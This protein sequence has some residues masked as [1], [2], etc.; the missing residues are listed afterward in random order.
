MPVTVKQ[1]A[2]LAGV[3]R[4]TV[5][6]ALNGRGNVR[7][8][9][10]KKILAIAQEMGYTPNRAGKALA[11]QRKNLS[12]GMIANAEG[13]EFFDEVLRGARTAI[14]EYAD[15]GISLQIAGGRRYDVDQQLSQLE[16]MRSAGVSGIAISPINLPQIEQKIN[17]LIEQG[18]RILTVNSDIEN[19]RRLCYVGCNYYQSGVTAGGMLRLMRPQG[20]RAGIITGSV[21]MLGHNHRMKGFSDVLKSMPDSTVVD[22]C[23]SLDEAEIAYQVTRDMLTSHPEI[24]TLYFAAAGAV[25]GMQAAVDLGLNQ[26]T[27]ISCDDTEEIREL[28]QKGL[29][30]ATVCQE[31]FRQGYRA[32]QILFDSIVNNISPAEEFCYMDNIIRIR[33]NL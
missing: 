29:I 12:F 1:I 23:E 19:T 3:S 30:Q 27:V 31:P 28:V 6:R 24:N 25:G 26:L 8:E 21:R 5:D 33:E 15:F 11:Y 16:Q 9:I 4:G 13:N 10:E 2:E 32:M 7:P 22:I 17:E 20:V 18:I 14:D